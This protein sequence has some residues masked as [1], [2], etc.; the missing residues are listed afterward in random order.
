VK[1]NVRQE[2][3][4]KSSI[5]TFPC[6]QIQTIRTKAGVDIAMKPVVD[7]IG[8]AWQPQSTKIKDSGRHND[9]VIPVKTNVER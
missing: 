1:T 8:L 3:F 9:I 4:K 2:N 6:D 7:N 5:D